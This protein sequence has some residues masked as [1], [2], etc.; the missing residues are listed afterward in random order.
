[1]ENPIKMDDLGVPLF[2]ETPTWR[3]DLDQILQSSTTCKLHLIESAQILIGFFLEIEPK[4]N[5]KKYVVF[6]DWIQRDTHLC[7]FLQFFWRPK[8]TTPAS[9]GLCCRM[10]FKVCQ[11]QRCQDSMKVHHWKNGKN[12]Q[13]QNLEIFFTGLIFGVLTVMGNIM[14]KF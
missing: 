7:Y 8:K 6:K 10:T 14:I 4:E 2:L 11:C 9:R 5:L 13:D 12:S 3:R 1:M